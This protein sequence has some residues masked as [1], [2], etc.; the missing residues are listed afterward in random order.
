MTTLLS[1]RYS[2]ICDTVGFLKCDARVA[3]QAFVDWQ[4]PI[5]R[6]RGV[7]VSAAP[8][9]DRFPDAVLRLLPLTNIEA[10]RFLFIPTRS[11]WT[12]FFDNGHQGTDVFAQLSYLSEKLGCDAVRA[13]HLETANTAGWPATIFELY[14]AHQT[15]W[16][17]VVRAV[18]LV[19][20]GYRWSFSESGTVQPFED[21]AAY[22]ERTIKKR[23]N[24]GMLIR[25]LQALGI[26][27]A[28]DDFF[29][30]AGSEA[31]FV[32]KQGPSA[33]GIREFALAES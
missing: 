26:D 30:P 5:Q 31:I 11:E 23:F 25:Y 22:K 29:L 9:A 14:G 2:P 7:S 33:S 13:S 1:G 16:L 32:E 15:D 4:S 21:V 28:D 27:A 3:A 12:A 10:R 18:G 8:I 24:G 19:H 20:D 6:T 17:N